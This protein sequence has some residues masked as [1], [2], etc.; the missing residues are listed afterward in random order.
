M[1][2]RL[3]YFTFAPLYVIL[4]LILSSLDQNIVGAFSFGIKDFVLHAVEYNILGVTLIWA[5]YRDKLPSEFRNSYLLAISTGSL[6]A[7]LDEVYQAFVPTRF[8]TIED[9]VADIFGLIL[10]VITFSLLM[11]IKPLENFR[12][13]A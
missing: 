8:S 10:S 12:Q 5:F 4:I 6:I 1:G 9:V 13:H 2:Y 11:K 7:I 3:K